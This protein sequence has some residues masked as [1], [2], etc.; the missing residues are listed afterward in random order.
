MALTVRTL[1]DFP[2]YH[3][4]TLNN[5]GW[6]YLE[7]LDNINQEKPEDTNQ[8]AATLQSAYDTFKNAIV[9]ASKLRELES[10]DETKQKHDL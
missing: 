4:G 3:I 7:K 9:R 5:L 10:G 2:L 8:K 6:T 1:D